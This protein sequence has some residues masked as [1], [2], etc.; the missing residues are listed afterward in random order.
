MP[1][2]LHL[3]SQTGFSCPRKA[4]RLVKVSIDHSRAVASAEQESK[5]FGGAADP[6]KGS[7]ATEYTGPL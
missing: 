2:G 3:T 7:N 4:T 5:Y 6:L 1:R